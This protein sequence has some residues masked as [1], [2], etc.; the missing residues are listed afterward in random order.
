M[1]RRANTPLVPAGLRLFKDNIL[2]KG[3]IF[4]AST[5]AGWAEGLRLPLTGETAFF[6]GC[7]YQF[8][9]EAEGILAAA[10]TL[11][12]HDLPWEG[13][14]GLARWLDRLGINLADLYGRVFYPQRQKKDSPLRDAV[15]VL[16]WLG[17]QVSI[18][19]EEEPCCGAPLYYA[20]FH[21][22][23]T[24]QAKKGADLWRKKGVRQVIGIVPSCT[25]ALRVL[26][27]RHLEGWGVKVRHFLEVVREGMKRG[28]SFRLE[29]ETVVTYHDPCILSRYLGVTEEPREILRAIAGVV[30]VEP[31]RTSREWSTCCGG[32]GG[33]EL[34]YPE[35]SQMIAANRVRELLE[36]GASVICTSCPGCLVQ[37]KKG[38]KAIGAKGVVV[39]DMAQLLRS[40]MVEE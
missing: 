17:V 40:A 9:E 22:G 34:I 26:Y 27:P 7:G 31:A 15:E 35:I 36:T 10:R 37:L 13:G 1:P 25:Y 28:K 3:N 33:F 12:A 5:K 24:A 16:K 18:L 21:K 20:G 38:V 23:F 32:G 2:K 14:I 8:L 19:G 4:G 39:L 11:D 29:H 30:F 6:A